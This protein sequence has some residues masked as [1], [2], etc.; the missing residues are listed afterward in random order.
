MTKLC[1]SCLAPPSRR[2]LPRDMPK[3]GHRAEHPQHVCCLV[4][5]CHGE[6]MQKR[7]KKGEKNLF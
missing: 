4:F 7:M 2:L 6:Q 3:T 1:H 5:V